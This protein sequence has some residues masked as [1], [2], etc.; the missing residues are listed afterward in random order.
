MIS[1]QDDAESDDSEISV[2]KWK[3]LK[4]KLKPRTANASLVVL[5][6][7]LP[8]ASGVPVRSRRT[9]PV[10]ESV[11]MKSTASSGK[12]LFEPPAIPS[13]ASSIRLPIELPVIAPAAVNSVPSVRVDV[14]PPSVQ[15]PCSSHQGP[16]ALTIIKGISRSEHASIHPTTL[17]NEH[18]GELAEDRPMTPASARRVEQATNKSPISP[19]SVRP[20]T[21]QHFKLLLQAKKSGEAQKVP[22]TLPEALVFI[23]SLL[24]SVI[25]GDLS[26]DKI[27]QVVDTIMGF[28]QERYRLGPFIAPFPNEQILSRLRIACKYLPVALL[29]QYTDLECL[30]TILRVPILQQHVIQYSLAAIKMANQVHDARTA[31]QLTMLVVRRFKEH[32]QPSQL[33][34]LR[35]DLVSDVPKETKVACRMCHYPLT[36]PLQESCADGCRTRFAVCYLTGNIVDA[37]DCSRCLLCDSTFAMVSKKDSHGVSIA[38]HSSAVVVCPICQCSSSLVRM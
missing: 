15:A 34:A 4:I 38:T 35:N 27:L 25:M 33:E 26:H 11:L 9:V 20:S 2:P 21:N 17:L 29:C 16:P 8:V 6:P 5:P 19:V 1:S 32:I 10:S 12:P 24:E 23:D 14:D 18:P 30:L 37:D 22:P 36:D 28:I 13:G 7:A 31:A 3:G